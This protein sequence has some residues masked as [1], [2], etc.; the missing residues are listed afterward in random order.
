MGQQGRR[1]AVWFD[2]L[3]ICLK[4][5]IAQ[6]AQKLR[7]QHSH[8]RLERQN[9]AFASAF[10]AP[11]ESVSQWSRSAPGNAKMEHGDAQ[12]SYELKQHQETQQRVHVALNSNIDRP[13]SAADAIE[14]A[15]GILI[16]LILWFLL[17]Q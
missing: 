16:P 3:A 12:S 4:Q 10:L 15:G 1:N 9:K 5:S 17:P 13:K 11:S 8:A 7:P 2:R 6:L 14:D